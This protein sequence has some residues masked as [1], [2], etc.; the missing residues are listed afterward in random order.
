MSRL[1]EIIGRGR[2][3]RLLVS[4]RD[5]SELEDAISGGADWIDFKEPDEGALGPV[6]VEMASRMVEAINERTPISAAL[7][8][9]VDWQNSPSQRILTVQGIGVVKLG[10]AGLASERNWEA[11]WLDFNQHAF[12][13]GKQLAA[14]VYADWQRAVAPQPD[15]V[16][17]M[18]IR[19]GAKYVL[20][21]TWDKK[22]CSTMSCF[23]PGELEQFVSQIN[24]SGMATVLAGS[25]Q[26]ADV[27]S[28]TEMGAD[29]I[30]VR[31]AACEG[32]RTNKI[33][34]DSVRAIRE[35]LDLATS[36]DFT[37]TIDQ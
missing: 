34:P 17:A 14:V 12:D 22:S 28:A 29:I 21:D 8:E 31:G 35:A 18:A 32:L 10:L 36:A 9:L 23:S 27:P 37:V 26:L 7:G 1:D 25:L 30:A 33:N 16:L 11:M 6:S 24:R 13:Q 3:P 15:A 20:I 4:V 19:A 5:E 2:R